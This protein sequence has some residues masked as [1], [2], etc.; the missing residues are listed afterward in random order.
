MLNFS[1]EKRIYPEI[2]FRCKDTEKTGCF[3]THPPSPSQQ[4]GRRVKNTKGNEP[5]LVKSDY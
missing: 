4:A 3:L 5:G 2:K 1:G